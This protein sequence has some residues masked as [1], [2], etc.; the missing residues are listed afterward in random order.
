MRRS[1][2]CFALVVTVWVTGFDS[3]ASAAGRRRRS[4]CSDPCAPCAATQPV[5][6][7]GCGVAAAPAASPAKEC[8]APSWTELRVVLEPTYVTEKRSLCST[9]YKDEERSRVITSY[10]TVPIT[11]ERVRVNTVMKPITETKLVE[12]TSQVAV[13]TEEQKS[14][15]IKVPVWTDEEET[16]VVKVPVIKEVEETYTVKV[17]VLKDVEFTYSVNVPFP[18]VRTGTRT[19]SNIVPV[20][21]THTVNFCVPTTHT[22][23]KAIDR[24]HWEN[25]TAQAA[26]GRGQP[27]RYTTNRVWVPDVQNEESSS[28]VSQQQPT[29]VEYLVYEQ[30]YT[31]LPF[32]C[33]CIEYR[34]EPRTGTK[35]EVVYQDEQRT[36][37]RTAVA[38]EDETRTRTKKVLSFKDEERTETYPVIT[39]KPET[40]SKEVQY[41]VYVPESKTETY[42]VTRHEKVLDHRL[43]TYLTRVPVPVVK[44]VD[45]QV[46]KMVPKVIS[47]TV[48]PCSGREPRTVSVLPATQYVAA[49]VQPAC[50][51]DGK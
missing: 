33:A 13:Q 50:C 26:V 44:E 22:Q 43:E 45:V 19:V 35:Q 38:Y 29:Q 30:R 40:L 34:P 5:G 10:K 41:T 28:I 21:K 20:V 6:C 14:Y 7:A 25:Q 23:T 48:S 18:I 46:T 12:Y 36:R 17:P 39:Y 15:T 11:E 49:N 42:T 2:C 16:Y 51:G 37:T 1:A 47:V 4:G 31:S 27:A 32:E 24:G 8:I 9:S 3:T